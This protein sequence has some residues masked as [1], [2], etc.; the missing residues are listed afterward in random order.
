MRSRTSSVTS[1]RPAPLGR[2]L[3]SL[4]VLWL[5]AGV[6]VQAAP[7][8][9]PGPVTE[10]VTPPERIHYVQPTYPETARKN[11]IEGEVV[12]DL[13]V[14]KTGDV[15]SVEVSESDP[16][17]DEA[18]TEAVRQWKF[19]PARKQD[20]PVSVYFTVKVRFRLDGDKKHPSGDDH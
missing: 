6:C 3:Q 20:E 14:G 19:R 10:D 12:L 11:G 2:L 1:D 18:A 9:A 5:A 4:L 15:E 17:F 7:A 13:V 16:A 8:D